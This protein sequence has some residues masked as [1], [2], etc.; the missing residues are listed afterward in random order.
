MQGLRFCAFFLVFLQHTNI[1]GNY[2]GTFGVSIFFCLSGFVTAYSFECKKDK[3]NLSIR[4]MII[5]TYQR[6]KKFIVLYEIFMIIAILGSVIKKNTC[7]NTYNILR[8][9][10]NLLLIQSWVP[11]RTIVFSYNAATWFLSTLVFLY[12]ITIPIIEIAVKLVDN[13]ISKTKVFIFLLTIIILYTII[14]LILGINYGNN[15]FES[16]YWSYV[17]PISRICDYF[18]GCTLGILF[19]RKDKVAN[20]NMK[21]YTIMEVISI[22]MGIVACIIYNY[23]PNYLHDDILF[24][25]ISLFLIWIFSYENGVVSKILQSKIFVY[26]GNIGLELFICHSIVIEI[27]NLFGEK[28]FFSLFI[29]KLIIVVMFSYM[30]YKIENLFKKYS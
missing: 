20:K 26:L 28:S 13:L 6:I 16:W 4:E 24:L 25:P 5:F 29:V 15:E 30:I 23:I 3:P 18:C 9:L 27:L 21:F 22:I 1:C 10:A 11:D 2:S 12:F 8:I 17:F 19:L 7:I 14:T